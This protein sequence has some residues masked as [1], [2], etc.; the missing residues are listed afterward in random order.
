MK[1]RKHSA[2]EL[3]RAC[4]WALKF[5]GLEDWRITIFWRRRPAWVERAEALGT[6]RFWR[7]YKR[8]D[9]WINFVECESQKIPPLRAL[10]HEMLH[11][12]L[13][14]IEIDRKSDAVE[15]ALC[16]LEQ[17]VYLACRKGIK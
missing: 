9:I 16:R 1:R 8:A 6:T 4:A 14:D 12:M 5:L 15:F 2:L 13:I 10:C 3:R 11:I 7:D 17:A